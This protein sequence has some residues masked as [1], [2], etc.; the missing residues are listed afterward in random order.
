M[1]F[2]SRIISRLFFLLALLVVLSACISEKDYRGELEIY[3]R[4]SELSIKPNGQ[5]WLSTAVGNTYHTDSVTGNWKYGSL[6]LKPKNSD[7]VFGTPGLDRISFFNNEI[8]IITGYISDKSSNK[9]DKIFRTVNGG[10]NWNMLSFGGDEWIYD[11]FVSSHGHA[12]MGGSGGNLY[13]SG[14]FGKT[15]TNKTP[16]FNNSTR[17]SSIFMQDSGFGVVGALHNGIKITQDHGKTWDAIETPLDQKKYKKAKSGYSDDRINKIVLYGDHFIVNQNGYIFYTEV[18]RIDWKAIKGTSLVDFTLDRENDVLYGI[19]EEL[20]IIRIDKE[21]RNTIFNS[22]P[23][24]SNPL[25]I[26]AINGMVYV[27]DGQYMVYEISN[28]HFV[29]SYPLTDQHVTR[30]IN[31]IKKH[32]HILWGVTDNNIYNSDDFG[33]RWYRLGYTNFAVRDF[34]IKND[35]E[36]ILW[37]GHGNN[38]TFNKKEATLKEIADFKD[39]DVIQIIKKDGVWVAYGGMQYETTQRVDVSRTFFGGQFR[40][41]RNYGFVF[42]SRDKGNH[43]TLIDKWEEGGVANCFVDNNSNIYLY[44]YLG[45]IRRINIK[46]KSIKSEN[47]L[48]ATRMNSNKVPYFQESRGFYFTDNNVGYVNG[49]THW[50]GNSSYKSENGGGSWSKIKNKT[51]PYSHVLP[52]EKLNIVNTNAEVYKLDSL[53]EKALLF[54]LSG[55]IGKESYIADISKDNKD[56][57][58]IRTSNKKLYLCNLNSKCKEL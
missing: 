1:C 16:P 41:S 30:D 10:K 9:H 31:R 46:S 4:V 53:G 38:Y 25:D 19:D 22:I 45:S 39:H 48:I 56:N 51:F 24:K 26:K 55:K 33:K 57:I 49:W 40:G 11:V 36:I 12:W 52:M 5:I 6:Q 32:N 27:I 17:T 29:N 14:D 50:L 7:D 18:A 23:L 37:D 8:G 44:S 47:L 35:N 20:R 34:I 13:Y 21:L 58:L 43:W 3:G 54:K 15:W 42:T 28:K 2:I